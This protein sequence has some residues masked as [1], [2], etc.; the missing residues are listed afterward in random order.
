MTIKLVANNCRIPVTYS[1]LTSWVHNCWTKHRMGAGGCTAIQPVFLNGLIS[2]N[3][4]QDA[5]YDFTLKAGIY[6]KG[7]FT[8]FTFSGATSV[9][10][11]KSW[12][13]GV[14]D[15]LTL[16]INPG[17]EFY[18]TNRRVANDAGAAGSYNVISNTYGATAKQDGIISGTDSTK[19]HTLGVGLAY[20]AKCLPTPVINDATGAITSIIK[21]PNNLGTGYTGGGNLSIWYGP[22]GSNVPGSQNPGTGVTGYTN[23][24]G[25]VLS[26]ITV[27]SGGTLHRSS[28]PPQCFIG[29]AGTAATGFGT[30][31]QIYGPSAILGTPLYKMPCC[32]INGDSVSSTG[33]VDT[34]G[35]LYS[36]YT[37]FEQALAARGVGTM[38]IS[39]TGESMAGWTANNTRQ[40]AFIDYLRNTLGLTL[41]NVIVPLGINDFNS[42]NNSNVITATQTQLATIISTWRTRGA[43]V[44]VVTIPPSTTSSD[45][46][47]TLANQTATL[48]GGA[49]T[50]YA[51]SGRV[52]Q[53]NQSLLNGTVD[54]DFQIDASK[55]SRASGSNS[56]KFRVDIYGGDIATT[57]DGIHYSAGAG[58][59]FL[60]QNVSIPPLYAA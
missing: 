36:N 58:I 59:P 30:A 13:K 7:K 20:G 1:T 8:P 22:A 2:T 48:V 16:T 17:D 29:G 11:S 23:P 40:L 49:S 43:K 24:S 42:N 41:D 3:S 19:D 32:L 12:G 46:W 54:S 53:F 45:N 57:S 44:G 31:T 38:N 50:N 55:W 15:A 37:F 39:V 51:S 56:G 60:L 25:G 5:Y 28:N 52:E 10:V 35:D 4:E 9:S 33:S 18:I 26:S 21:D 6:Y 14:C 47:T 34:T 27:S